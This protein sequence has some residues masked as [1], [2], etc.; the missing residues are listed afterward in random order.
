[1]TTRA[2]QLRLS[3]V[4]ILMALFALTCVVATSYLED[5]PIEWQAYSLTSI[6]QHADDH[7]VVMVFITA[8]WNCCAQLVERDAI[9]TYWVR[10]LIRHNRVVPMLVDITNPG[11]R[12]DL[13]FGMEST[14]Y[15]PTPLI[16]IIAPD[17]T[18]S[19]IVLGDAFT[20]D[21]LYDALSDAIAL[22]SK[23]ANAG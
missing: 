17:T 4:L 12:V 9:E 14:L 1:M 11:S 2:L 20:E 15:P 22:S 6:K 13:P 5:P 3:H 8:D 23:A 18:A 19:P 7:R 16:G 21:E 10:R